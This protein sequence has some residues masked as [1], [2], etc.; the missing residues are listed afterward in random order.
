[1]TETEFALLELRLL[2]SGTPYHVHQGER[3][4]VC[5]SP[6]C[7]NLFQPEPSYGPGETAT[8]VQYD[9]GDVHA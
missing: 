4:F 1:M 2:K 8:T 9:H 3:A 6:Y 5:T 7:R